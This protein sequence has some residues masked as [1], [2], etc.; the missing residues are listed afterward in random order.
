VDQL[1]QVAAE[2]TKLTEPLSAEHP[3]GRSLDDSQTLA[4]LEAYRVFGRLK[5]AADEPNWQ[6]LLKECLG[7]LTESKDLRVLA[8]L[9]AA[10][11]RIEPLSVTLQI[12]P[13][14]TTW[15]ERY[16]NEAHPRIDED[17]VARRNALMF[18]VDRLA[19]LDGL[20][21]ATVVHDARLGS[22]SVRHFEIA[23][24]ALQVTDTE[25]EPVSKD[26]IDSALAAADP[27]E[28]RRISDF[29]TAAAA[30]LLRVEALMLEK[31]GGYAAVPQLEG[32]L[33]ILQGMQKMLAP[34]ASPP[35][36]ACQEVAADP[37]SAANVSSGKPALQVGMIAS[38]DDV[39][40]VLDAVV[41]YYR[42]SEPGSLVPMIIERA[43]RL[44]SLNFLDALA[45]VAPEAVDAVKKAVG[46]R[47]QS[48][49]ATSR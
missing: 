32:L 45:E 46:A 38:R 4:A 3:C 37:L 23:T 8:Y 2:L 33:R 12:F 25:A 21:R 15:L 41:G 40:R 28:L 27:H 34:H 30:A 18:F 47:E 42:S 49:R 31:G 7:A 13:L 20:R 39:Q 36:P 48:S 19:I 5:A 22:F 26:V 6:S 44:V 43:Q 14:M 11:L 10:A 17:A 16:W 35:P 29:A 24:G 1:S 9:T